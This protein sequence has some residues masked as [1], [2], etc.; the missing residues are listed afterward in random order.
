[1]IPSGTRLEYAEALA[2]AAARK[3]A[4]QVNRRSSAA[5]TREASKAA[6]LKELQDEKLAALRARR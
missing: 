5:V 3:P 1:M 2:S 4:P 6:G